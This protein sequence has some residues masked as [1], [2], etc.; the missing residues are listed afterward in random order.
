L[1]QMHAGTFEAESREG[2]GSTFTVRLPLGTA[3]LS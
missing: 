1:V 2:H 3:H